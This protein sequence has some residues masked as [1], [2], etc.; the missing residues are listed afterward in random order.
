MID[1]EHAYAF[2]EVGGGGGGAPTLADDS[3]PYASCHVPRRYEEATHIPLVY[4]NRMLW[5]KPK[6]S[7][8]LVSHIDVSRQGGAGARVM[9]AI[10]A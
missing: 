2:V 8:A 10:P 4:S 6:E 5:P 3:R 9:C 1:A 7:N